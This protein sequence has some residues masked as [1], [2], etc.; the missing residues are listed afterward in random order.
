MPYTS[1]QISRWCAA[2]SAAC[3]YAVSTPCARARQRNSA[4][5]HRRKRCTLAEPACKTA[6]GCRGVKS[7]AASGT[8]RVAQE[9]GGTVRRAKEY[10][11]ERVLLRGST[12]DERA[13]GITTA[14]P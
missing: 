13:G 12:S 9:Y 11:T 6:H 4:F 2:T 5:S 3:A 1:V 7:T 8:V 14:S 10:G